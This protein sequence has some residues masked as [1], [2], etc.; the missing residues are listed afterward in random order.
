VSDMHMMLV[1]GKVAEVDMGPMFRRHRAAHIRARADVIGQ[2][3]S[4][5]GDEVF[6]L[7]EAYEAAERV[8]P[9]GLVNAAGNVAL[10][11]RQIEELGLA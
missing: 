7:E 11:L 10:V 6:S 2:A 4:M 8:L 5:L 1:D 3:A 9:P